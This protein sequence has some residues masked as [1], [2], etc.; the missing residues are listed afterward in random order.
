MGSVS[1]GNCGV[2]KG[3][4]GLA[5]GGKY[6]G[7]GEEM[8]SIGNGLV[9]GFGL[10][11]SMSFPL[12]AGGGRSFWNQLRSPGSVTNYA[13]NQAR[14]LASHKQHCLYNCYGLFLASDFFESDP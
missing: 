6:E 7:D 2:G 14:L 5:G 13:D 4:E 11:G 9:F 3:V 1:E 10:R 12:S 8:M